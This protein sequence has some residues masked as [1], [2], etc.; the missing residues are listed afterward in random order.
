MLQ[1]LA[2]AVAVAIR[3]LDLAGRVEAEPELLLALGQLE[4]VRR[5]ARDDDVVALAERHAADDGAQHAA[6]AVHVEHLVALSVAVEAVELLGRLADRHLDVVVEH[7]EAAAGDGIAARLHAVRVG[8]AVHMRIGNPLVT[9]NGAEV[10]NG[11]EPARRLEVEQD[12]LVTREALVAHHLLDEQRRAAAVRADLDVPLRGDVAEPGV[13]HQR[14]PLR[15]C[16]RSIA[17]N[18]ALKLPSPKPREPW[19]SMISKKIVGL[20]PSGLVKICSR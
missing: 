11:V 3:R 6:A 9:L 13:T 20:S 1:Q 19:R 4:G 5:A 17:S 16:S 8:E 14:F 15:S 18:R 2:V 7:Q 12:R 10:A